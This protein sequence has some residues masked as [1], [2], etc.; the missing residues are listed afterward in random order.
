MGRDRLAEEERHGDH[1]KPI[2][3]DR[4]SHVEPGSTRV[5]AATLAGDAARR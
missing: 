4:Q 5:I 1:H 2:T 3:K